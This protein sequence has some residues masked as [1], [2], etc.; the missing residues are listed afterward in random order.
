MDF[1]MNLPR[2]IPTA[3]N[4]APIVRAV[5]ALLMVISILATITRVMM[6]LMT[7]R[8]LTVDDCFLSAATVS[9]KL[10]PM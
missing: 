2:E 8:G 4:K 6:K 1:I 3:F 7:T 10:L 5:T 9:F